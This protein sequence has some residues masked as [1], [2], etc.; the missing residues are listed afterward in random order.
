MKILI[1]EDDE[2]LRRSF[3]RALKDLSDEI[4]ESSS[5]SAAKAAL[6]AQPDLVILDVHLPDG[7]GVELAQLI[8]RMRPMPLTIAVSGEA[9]AE[10]A[11]RLKEYGVQAYIAKPFSLADFKST[12]KDLLETPPDLTPHLLPLVGKSTF[13]EVHTSVRKRMLEQAL[14]MAKGN[15]T[16]A[17]ELLCVSRQAVQQMINDF[18]L[19]D[20]DGSNH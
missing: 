4:T 14:S 11:F 3:V 18:E 1:V 10:Q 12:I 9:S 13:R 15:K 8:S 6:Q 5:M 17:A 19:H 2:I 20:A 16:K 7:D